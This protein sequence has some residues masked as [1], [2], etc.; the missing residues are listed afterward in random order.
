MVLSTVNHTQALMIDISGAD[1]EEMDGVWWKLVNH[2]QNV[3]TE[4]NC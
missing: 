4:N 3:M 1:F 2:Y